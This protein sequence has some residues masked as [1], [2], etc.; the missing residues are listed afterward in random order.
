MATF[1]Y[2]LVSLFTWN[3]MITYATSEAKCALKK[4]KEMMVGSNSSYGCIMM[5]SARREYYET[6]QIHESGR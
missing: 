1:E 4:N 3:L 6:P 5:P 2:Y